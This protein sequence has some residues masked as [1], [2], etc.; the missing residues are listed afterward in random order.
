M[1][2]LPDT[3][4]DFKS[5]L[6]KNRWQLMQT[7]IS[8]RHSPQKWIRFNRRSWRLIWSLRSQVRSSCLSLRGN[9]FKLESLSKRRKVFGLWPRTVSLSEPNI[10]IHWPTK[11]NTTNWTNQTSSMMPKRSRSS[12]KSAKNTR[13]NLK[14]V[15]TW[16]ESMNRHRRSSISNV[17]SSRL[18]GRETKGSTWTRQ[19]SF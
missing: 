11:S 9:R 12:A 13:K 18:I 16:L 8:G 17:C 7:L 14:L 1:N 6:R 19:Q 10:R 5:R 3:L 15:K 2:K 4:S